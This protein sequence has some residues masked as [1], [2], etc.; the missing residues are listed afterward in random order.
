MSKAIVTIFLVLLVPALLCA[1]TVEIKGRVIDA[2]TK[3]ALV[4]AT[5]SIQGTTMGASTDAQGNYTIANVPPGSYTFRFGFV[6]YVSTQRVAAVRGEQGLVIDVALVPTTVE[7]GEVVV[8][9][10]R[11]RER[12]T[13]VAFTNV[14]KM[15]IEEKIHGQDAPLL[16]QGHPRGLLPIRPTASAT[17]NPRCSSAGS[18][19]TT[20]RC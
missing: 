5:V 4:G 15:D 16:Y 13:P 9:R 7:A 3:E 19:R 1:Q 17:A 2:S 8:E 12:E 18:A 10:N 6:G 11:A 20:C 14:N